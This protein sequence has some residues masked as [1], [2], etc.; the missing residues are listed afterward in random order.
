MTVGPQF[1]GHTVVQP[2]SSANSSADGRVGRAARRAGRGDDPRVAVA[3]RACR[4][5]SGGR[6]RRDR[7]GRR[8][9][10]ARSAPRP[11]D[12][13]PRWP[14]RPWSSVAR[15]GRAARDRDGRRLRAG[16]ARSVCDRGVYDYIA[17]G[18]GDERTL[19]ENRRAFDRWMLCV[20]GTCGGRPN[21]TADQPCS[22]HDLA[23]RSSSRRGRCQRRS[24]PT[25]SSRPA[26][27]ERRSGSLMVVSSTVYDIIEEVAG[28]ATGPAWWQLYLANDRGFS[29][30]MLARVAS[31]GYR[32]IVWTVDLPAWGLRHRDTRND[33]EPP[34]GPRRAATTSTTRRCPG[35]TCGGSA[36]TPAGSPSS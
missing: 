35:T 3:R 11:S 5:R 20:R 22:A 8:R 31:L 12:R 16:R 17:G 27:A 10:P 19:A 36:S 25:A 33:F 4:R 26:A 29:A 15:D 21:R 24:T 18:A 13:P 7:P 6:R 34:D 14:P 28:A 23:A 32:A 2:C 9:L 30:D 1:L